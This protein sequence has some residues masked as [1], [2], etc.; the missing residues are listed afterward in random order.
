MRNGQGNGKGNGATYWSSNKWTGDTRG[1]RE[2][3]PSEQPKKPNNMRN[4]TYK[5]V[6]KS[7]TTLTKPTIQYMSFWWHLALSLKL[8]LSHNQSQTPQTYCQPRVSECAWVATELQK[9]KV[10]FASL[11]SDWPQVRK[12]DAIKWQFQVGFQFSIVL[13][14]FGWMD[15][16]NSW[17]YFL[18]FGLFRT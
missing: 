14:T 11:V 2:K 15:G 12:A 9:K 5:K 3:W 16:Y 1:N 8:I 4:Y 13:L 18:L 10:V 17:I 6:S 7:S